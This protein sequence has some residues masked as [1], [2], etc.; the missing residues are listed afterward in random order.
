MGLWPIAA[1]GVLAA[2]QLVLV[3]VLCHVQHGIAVRRR[4]SAIGPPPRRPGPDVEGERVTLEGTLQSV[5]PSRD[6]SPLVVSRVGRGR[7]VGS[8]TALVLAVGDDH[9]ALD[10]EME[11]VV[12]S[13]ER[14]PPDDD[15]RPDLL[16]LCREVSAGDHVIVRGT[17][18][19]ASTTAPSTYRRNAIRWSLHGEREPLRIAFEGRPRLGG[20]HRFFVAALPSG[21]VAAAGAL[22]IAGAAVVGMGPSRPPPDAPPIEPGTLTAA[23]RQ[24]CHDASGDDF[25]Q[26]GAASAVGP[27]CR[28][29]LSP[30]E[31][32]LQR[33]R[34]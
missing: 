29:E 12:G 19:R 18:R 15:G 1:V 13:R 33:P 6:T 24:A 17:L 11:V 14:V 25:A 23:S 31:A 2:S 7:R 4:R 16:A 20:T 8:R 10:G 5:D 26:V 21:C 9:V 3:L 30:D 32:P 28:G 27:A 34:Q 22:A